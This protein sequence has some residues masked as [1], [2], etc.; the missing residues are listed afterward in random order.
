MQLAA[1]TEPCSHV[2][3]GCCLL[4]FSNFNMPPWC[5]SYMNWQCCQRQSCQCT[6]DHFFPHEEEVNLMD[7]VA[8]NKNRRYHLFKALY[9]ALGTLRVPVCGNWAKESPSSH[10]KKTKEKEANSSH[11]K[12][13][14]SISKWIFLR[15]RGNSTRM[16]SAHGS[17]TNWYDSKQQQWQTSPDLGSHRLSVESWC[18]V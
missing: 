9:F 7:L 3:L 11:C 17:H 2:F 4:V 6:A 1:L 5:Y 14:W 12:A 15:F 16:S 13:V 8:Q 10:E 18:M